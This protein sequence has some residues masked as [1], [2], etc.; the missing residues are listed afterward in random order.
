ML[1]RYNTSE[2]RRSAAEI[3]SSALCPL[4]CKYCYIPKTDQMKELQK[5]IIE[6]L[7]NKTFI[8]DLEKFYGKDLEH[9]S[10]WGAEPTLTL[11]LVSKTIPDLIKKFPNLKSISFSTSLIIKPGGIVDF[12]KVLT[13]TKRKLNFEC[14]ISLDGPAFITDVN[15]I[16]G[17]AQ[18]IPENFFYLVKELNTINLGNLLNIKFHFKPTLTLDNIRMLNKKPSKIK[19]YFDYFEAIF[20]KYEKGNKNSQVKLIYGSSPTLAV[21]GKYTSMDGKELATFFK[22]LRILAKE[23]KENRYWTHIQGSLNNYVFRFERLIQYQNE[24]FTKPSMFSCSGGDSNFGLGIEQDFHLCHRMFFLNNKEYIDSIFSQKDIGNWDISLFQRGN[25]DL[26]NNRYIINTKNKKDW[27]RGLYILRNYHDFTRLKNSYTVA[28][29]KELAISGQAD[30]R[31]LKDD[32]LCQI[33]ALF[34][35]SG[36]GCPAENLLNTGVIHFAPISTIRIF[37]NGAFLEILKDHYEN[38][39]KR[40]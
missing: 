18:K 34:L 27:S 5:R 8:K 21:P 29:L 9:L 3:F 6:K 23:N 31:Y 30:K 15:R 28:M 2:K 22:N 17:A 7:E 11:N 32:E 14:Q 36:L 12:I 10:L 37:A 13:K 19:E 4:N 25:I 26:V 38:F 1:I 40:E 39:S 33:F 24:L 16:K 35:N 20:Q